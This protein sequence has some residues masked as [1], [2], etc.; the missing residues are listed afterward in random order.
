MPKHPY[1]DTA[2]LYG[3]LALLVVVIAYA[4]G[5]DV[6]KALVTAIFVYIVAT[7]WSWRSWRNRLRARRCARNKRSGCERDGDARRE[8]RRALRRSGADPRTSRKRAERSIVVDRSAAADASQQP[9]PGG[10]RA[11][12][13]LVVYGGSGKAARNPDALRA[14]VRSLLEL[15]DDETLLVQSGKPVG[16]F[17]THALRRAC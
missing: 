16:V 17:R 6:V 2:I 14:I 12:E 11:P 3:V 9:R 15:G 5:G 7:L 4:T 13:E 8:G 1:R 10:R